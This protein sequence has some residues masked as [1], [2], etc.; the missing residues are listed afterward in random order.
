MEHSKN[1]DK[2]Q[3][4]YNNSCW[5]IDRVFNAVGKWIT[6]EEYKEITNFDY[7]NKATQ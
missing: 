7:P 4:Y 5:N 1:F 3:T 2:V 6:E